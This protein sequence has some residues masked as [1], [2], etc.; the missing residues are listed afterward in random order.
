MMYASLAPLHDK[1]TLALFEFYFLMHDK[2]TIKESPNDNRESELFYGNQRWHLG[3]SDAP[4]ST[5][6]ESH[7]KEW[8]WKLTMR[9][10]VAPG[11]FRSIILTGG[12]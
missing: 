2:C 1:S 8:I 5:T 7:L 9:K 4:S 11:N 10:S 3:H 12:C 6:H